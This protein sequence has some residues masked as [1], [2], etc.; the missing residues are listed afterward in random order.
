M[1]DY[2]DFSLRHALATGLSGDRLLTWYEDRDTR[3]R[4]VCVK[5]CRQG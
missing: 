1:T 2:A 3:T 5:Y 4:A